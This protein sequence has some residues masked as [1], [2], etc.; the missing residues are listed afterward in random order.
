M[1]ICSFSVLCFSFGVLMTAILAL[2]KRR[3]EIAIRFGVFS[4]SIVGWGIIFSSWISQNYS[5]EKILF[6]VR[7]SYHFVLFIPVFWIHFVFTFINKREPFKFFYPL[8]YLF[9]LVL[10]PFCMTEHIFLSLYSY[11]VNGF[12]Y[13]PQPAFLHHLHTLH[14]M[15]LVP[16]GLYELIRAYFKSSGI[17]RMKCGY[18]V[19]GTLIGYF[20]GGGI[21]LFFYK[22]PFPMG[23]L[24]TMPIYPI[25]TSIALLKYGL[26]DEEHLIAAFQR[27]KLMAIGT[28]AASLNHELKNPLFIARGKAET[29]LDQIDRGVSVSDGQAKQTVASI[30]LQ[31][32]RASEIIQKF[33]DF[34]KPFY[35]ETRKENVLVREAFESVLQLVSAEFA[36]NR[37]K[38]EVLPTDELSV[39][40]NARQF[41]EILFNLTM[42]A[43][44]AIERRGQE[45]GV[46]VQDKPH[47]LITFNAFQPNGKVIIEISDSGSGIPKNKQRKIFEPFYSTKGEKGSGLGLYITKQL[48][49]RNGGKIKVNSK[50]GHGTTFRLELVGK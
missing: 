1:N 3:D 41:E 29:F 25:L 46:W 48:V 15:T 5:P 2:V 20:S 19:L 11:P 24:V 35:Q 32:K 36:L 12:K 28:M 44:H 6:L 16:Y 31:V 37:V 40:I 10:L 43:C 39:N 23:F 9:A 49:E 4:V 33:S 38:I 8:N 21:Y 50:L 26:F 47:G 22:I 13:V 34:A 14:F 30:Y 45:A 18:L 7:L 42:N 17:V 27:E